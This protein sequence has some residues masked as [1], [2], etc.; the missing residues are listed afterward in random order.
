MQKRS[1]RKCNEG[2]KLI[3]KYIKTINAMDGKESNEKKKKQEAVTKN[4][5]SIYNWTRVKTKIIMTV[6][7][8]TTASFI[9]LAR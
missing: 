8:T 1:K 2:K 4:K 9:L 5:R 7:L 6:L 3:S